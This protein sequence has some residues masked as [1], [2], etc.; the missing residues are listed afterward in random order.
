MS[1]CRF[2][3]IKTKKS[4]EVVQGLQQLSL[5]CENRKD[6]HGF[7][8]IDATNNIRQIQLLFG[9][10]VL[11]WFA[12]KGLTFSRTNRDLEIP[13]GIGFQKGARILHPLEDKTQME[14]VLAE[15]RDAEFPAEWSERILEKFAGEQQ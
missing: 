15:A 11:E 4:E 2:Y 9:E 7:L 5:G 12:G 8:W 10:I 3:L 13:E 1:S 14:S 6:A